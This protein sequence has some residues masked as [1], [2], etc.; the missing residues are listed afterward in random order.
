MLEVLYFFYFN[1][2]KLALRTIRLASI[3]VG[4]IIISNYYSDREKIFSVVFRIYEK[5][6]IKRLFEDNNVYLEKNERSPPT[7][8]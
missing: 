1:L 2:R 6:C 5:Y 3:I 8:I 7:I 4:F